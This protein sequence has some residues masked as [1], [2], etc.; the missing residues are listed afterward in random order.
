MMYGSY[1]STHN[2][3]KLLCKKFPYV[4]YDNVLLYRLRR[5]A[6]VVHNVV[7]NEGLNRFIELVYHVKKKEG[8]FHVELM[9]PL[10]ILS[11]FIFNHPLWSYMQLDMNFSS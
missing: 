9:A 2:I 4:F 7:T 1:L 3:S 8:K 5:K 11:V 6:S 10:E